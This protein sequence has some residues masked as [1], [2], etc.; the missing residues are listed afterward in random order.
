MIN[1]KEIKEN[2]LDKLNLIGIEQRKVSYYLKQE[3]VLYDESLD[4]YIT[5]NIQVGKYSMKPITNGGN[6][7]HFGMFIGLFHED[8]PWIS[9]CSI[10]SRHLKEG[11][12]GADEYESCC[13]TYYEFSGHN[14]NKM[15]DKDDLEWSV[16]GVEFAI[17]ELASK[18]YKI[19]KQKYST[20]LDAIIF[21][22]KT[23][24]QQDLFDLAR[25]YNGL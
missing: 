17:N 8:K 10:M 19:L 15:L 20:A 23:D 14:S 24:C 13:E 4:S 25:K 16:Q 6:V 9:G 11:E 3:H 12:N 18:A 22:E 2:I 21:F 5:P 1:L 7:N